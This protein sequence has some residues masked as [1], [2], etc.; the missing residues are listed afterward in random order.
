[1]LHVSQSNLLSTGSVSFAHLRVFDI[2]LSST[3]TKTTAVALERCNSNDEV[4]LTL[5]T[6]QRPFQAPQLGFQSTKGRLPQ[7]RE[8]IPVSGTNTPRRLGLTRSPRT[9]RNEQSH[10]P[11]SSHLAVP[12]QGHPP[13][14]KLHNLSFNQHTVFLNH[15]QS[16]L[17]WD[18]HTRDAH[19]THGMTSWCC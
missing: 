16:S 19:K 5:T 13:R 6:A 11:G 3:S 17:S 14:A 1:M 4:P 15:K 7:R 8:C 12:S 18:Q 9:S 2:G 10:Q